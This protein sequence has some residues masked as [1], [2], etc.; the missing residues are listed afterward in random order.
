MPKQ[1]KIYF[2][3]CPIPHSPQMKEVVEPEH[4]FCAIYVLRPMFFKE[5]NSTSDHLL[6]LY[7]PYSEYAKKSQR[8]IRCFLLNIR[9]GMIDRLE[10]FIDHRIN[11]STLD[12]TG[13][14]SCGF[15]FDKDQYGMII[16]ELE[17]LG[18]VVEKKFE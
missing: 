8:F 3:E 5:H 16:T 10:R 4:E 15:F 1:V 17:S 9:N 18:Y 13:F 14:R 2:G 6:T 7:G 12:Q 11:D